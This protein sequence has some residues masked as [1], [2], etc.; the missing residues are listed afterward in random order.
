MAQGHLA[1]NTLTEDQKRKIEQLR[2]IGYLDGSKPAPTAT[3][4]T[5]H[6][7]GLAYSSL[8][9]VVSA[10]RPEALL[11]DMSGKVLHKWQCDIFR[12]WP[13]FDPIELSQQIKEEI[14]W[15]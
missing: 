10:H 9:L 14:K 6:E 2:S 7:D 15:L 3:N 1:D 12:V 13:D 8:N 11:M 5:V 4:V